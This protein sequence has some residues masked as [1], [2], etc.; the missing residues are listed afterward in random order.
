MLVKKRHMRGL[1]YNVIK[2]QTAFSFL[3]CDEGYVL[4]VCE[5]DSGLSYCVFSL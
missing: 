2:R 5:C 4:Q 1:M 3:L